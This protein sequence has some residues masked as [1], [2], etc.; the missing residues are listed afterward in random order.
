MVIPEG[1]TEIGKFAFFSCTGLTSVIIPEG[2]KEIGESADEIEREALLRL[3][4]AEKLMP[5][6]NLYPPLEECDRQDND[7]AKNAM[8]EYFTALDH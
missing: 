1:V 7:A 8:P 5:C 4:S 6:D 3:M 2:V